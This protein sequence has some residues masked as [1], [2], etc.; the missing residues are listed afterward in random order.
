MTLPKEK[1]VALLSAILQS[2]PMPSQK[3]LN[4]IEDFEREHK[5]TLNWYEHTDNV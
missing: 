1:V 3:V 4:L 5:L 2:E